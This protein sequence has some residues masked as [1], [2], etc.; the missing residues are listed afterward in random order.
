[1]SRDLIERLDLVLLVF[2]GAVISALAAF[3]AIRRPE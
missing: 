2:V 3:A 1:M